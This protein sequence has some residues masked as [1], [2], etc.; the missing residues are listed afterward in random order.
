MGQYSNVEVQINQ[1]SPSPV[2]EP[3]T[4]AMFGLGLLALFVVG[5][6]CQQ[7]TQAAP[8]LNAA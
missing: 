3:S 1:V 2:P 8:A 5:R 4:Y 7:V 6:K